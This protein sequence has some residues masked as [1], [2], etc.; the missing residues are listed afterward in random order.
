MRAKFIGLLVLLVGLGGFAFQARPS[1]VSAERLLQ[2]TPR[3]E[4]INIYFTEAGGEASRF[5]RSDS[6]LSRLAGLL[7]QLGASLYTLE[8]RTGFPSDAD[9]I[10]VAGPQTDFAPDQIARLWSYVNNGGKLLLL[11][12]PVIETRSSALPATSGLFQLM[13]AD[14]GLR[15]TADYLITDNGVQA[16]AAPVEGAT[17]TPNLARISNRFV[18]TNINT[19]HPITVGLEGEL[20]FFGARSLEVD[21]AIQGFIVTP[22]VFADPAFYGEVD[23]ARFVREGVLEFNIGTDTAAGSLAV[24][25]AF[26]DP[27]TGSRIV[28]VGDADFA[29][30]GLG[31][32]TAPR[33]S[34][35]FVHPANVRF[36]LNAVTWLVNAE[37]VALEFPTPGPTETATLTPTPTPTRTT[38]PLPTTESTEEVTATPTPGA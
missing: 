7:R 16:D 24:S 32:Q 19:Q 8:W 22:L 9:L 6:G 3:L 12:N 5:D 27:R 31:L 10:I 26:D 29:R 34:A 21:S 17:P 30:N 23:F 25:G 18:S 20:A 15:A 13:W 35:G 1:L 38:T 37:S 11:A 33:Y 36:L 2:E 14:F 4:G 28:L